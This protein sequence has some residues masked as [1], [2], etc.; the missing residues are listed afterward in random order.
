MPDDATVESAT[1]E[2]TDQHTDDQADGDAGTT[3][4]RGTV[5]ELLQA[6]T[7]QR[8]GAKP[9]GETDVD[10]DDTSGSDDDSDGDAKDD[11]DATDW[12]AEAEKWKKLA[13]KH[14]QRAKTNGTTAEQAS[15]TLSAIAKAL[16]LGEDTKPDPET[17]Q[18]S[19]SE[20]DDLLWELKL[21]RSADK[22]ARAVGA[23][24][25]LLVPMLFH[26]GALDDLEPDSDDWD[27]KVAEL[28]ADLVKKFPKLKAGT[29]VTT[30]RP[31]LKQGNRGR[32]AP[33][34]DGNEWLRRAG[35]G[36]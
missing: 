16:G 19:L 5:D 35:R 7:Q 2:V 13:R 11:Q 32:Q 31:D 1:D 33:V 21:E 22:A 23:D 29:T 27:D 3:S 25:D 12:K 6:V 18:R 24:P 20:K 4:G 26:G 14:E 9:T 36:G 15:E 10:E 17:L 30:P 28:A 8:N 34:V